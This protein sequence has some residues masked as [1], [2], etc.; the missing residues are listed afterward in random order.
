MAACLM[1]LL[2]RS[3]SAERHNL[4]VVIRLSRQI[5]LISLSAIPAGL[6]ALGC[7]VYLA[8][9]RWLSYAGGYFC[10]LWEV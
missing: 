10:W 7:G 4:S 2:Q 5:D 8:L 1:P 6:L 3:S 9:Q